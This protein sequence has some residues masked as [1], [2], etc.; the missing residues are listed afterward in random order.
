M[1][2]YQ[3]MHRVVM[4][5]IGGVATERNTQSDRYVEGEGVVHINL[6]RFQQNKYPGLK[7]GGGLAGM[8][9]IIL[10]IFKYIDI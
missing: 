4:H 10:D 9:V 3:V 8:Q 7:L 5:S 2:V 6:K 1:C